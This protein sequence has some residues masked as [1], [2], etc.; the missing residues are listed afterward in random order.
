M[1]VGKDQ[2]IEKQAGE[3]TLTAEQIAIIESTGDIVINA[4]AGS[5]KTTTIIEYAASRPKKSRILYL[6]FNKSVKLEAV[7]KF[8][9]RN[10]KNVT[11]E[12]AHSLAYR[13]IVPRFKY[14]VKNQGY[15]TH[16]I[17]ELLQLK[18]TGEKLTEYVIASHINKFITYFCNS[19]KA[20]VQDL[21]Y[22]DTIFDEK[23]RTFAKS[24]YKYIETGT[25]VLLAKM[26]KGEIPVIHDFY[27]KKFHWKVSFATFDNLKSKII[28]LI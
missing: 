26:N 22:L 5:G 11:V 6:A 3:K 2:V 28:K 10:L 4:V 17:A 9:E 1:A 25:R 8:E 16:E 24:L 21:N 12:T 27:L 18:G 13:Y 20:R 19:D 15:K 7:R 14:E 23:S